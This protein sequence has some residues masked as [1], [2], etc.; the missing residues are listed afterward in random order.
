MSLKHKLLRSSTLNVL[1]HVVKMVAMLLVTPFL[2]RSLGM[3]DYGTWLLLNTAVAFLNLLDGGITLSGTRFY[4]R[5]VGSQKDGD[6][7]GAQILSSLRWLY[8]RMGALCLLGTL[9]LCFS[10]SKIAPVEYEMSAQLVLGALGLG[11]S[12]RF[13]LRVHLVVLKSHLRY[14]LIVLASLIKVFVQT[15]LV[16]ALLAQ[17][18]GL[19]VLALAQLATEFLDQTLV[20]FFSRRTTAIQRSAKP[21]MKFIRELLSF[22]TLVLINLGSHQ[23]RRNSAPFIIAHHVGMSSVPLFGMAQ[24]LIMMLW[25]VVNTALGGILVTG[26]SQVAARSNQE[27]VRKKFLESL[28]FSVPLALFGATGLA[29]LG[30]A[31]LRCW[32]GPEFA[33]AGWVLWVLLIPYTIWLM[34]FP[35]ESLFISLGKHGLMARLGVVAALANVALCIGLAIPFGLPGVIGGIAIEMTLAYALGLPW[36]LRKALDLSLLRYFALILSQILRLSPFLLA[37][38]LLSRL[39]RLENYYSLAAASFLE[40][41]CFALGVVL[42][43]L[44]PAEKHQL[45]SRLSHFRSSP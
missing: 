26:F 2:V 36:M 8:H 10:V 24:R 12:L 37:A 20:V 4:S 21:D 39:F 25:E 19:V 14:D 40:C 22:S 23:L 1:D 31:F 32:L 44:T 15:A 41:C 7:T 38:T 3:Q 27:E 33:E 9:T 28:R 45:L 34:Q 6:A 11:S 30:P 18:Y 17:G 42:A 29:S 13:F 35:A 5:S 16:L 43:I